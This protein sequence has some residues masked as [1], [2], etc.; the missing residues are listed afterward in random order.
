MRII[1]PVDEWTLNFFFTFDDDLERKD[2][3]RAVIRELL[4]QTKYYLT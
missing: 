4:K 2:R 1:L 3:F